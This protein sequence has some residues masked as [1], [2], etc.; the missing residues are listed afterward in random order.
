MAKK[1]ITFSFKPTQDVRDVKLA[2]NFTDWEKGAIVMSKGRLGEW[3][4]QTSLEPGEYEYK[5]LADGAWLNDPKADRIVANGWGSANSIKV[6][7]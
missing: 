6:V 5:F 2:G 4:A 7:K 1:K 3:K